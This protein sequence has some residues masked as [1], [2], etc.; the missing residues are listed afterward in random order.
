ML[1]KLLY[2]WKKSCIISE[3][4]LDFSPLSVSSVCFGEQLQIL[5]IW[6][7]KTFLPVGLAV[8]CVIG[9]FMITYSS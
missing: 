1:I 5:M 7:E 2:K 4:F 8:F 6:K 3:R 9:V